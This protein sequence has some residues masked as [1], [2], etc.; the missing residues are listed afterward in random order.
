MKLSH[1]F[2][3]P[4]NRN[5]LPNFLAAHLL[6]VL[7]T[8]GFFVVA[9]T[10]GRDPETGAQEKR[11]QHHLNSLK[12]AN[13]NILAEGFMGSMT[14]GVDAIPAHLCYAQAEKASGEARVFL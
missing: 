1:L 11:L 2:A 14:F 12:D 3:R 7:A 8:S 13:G 9:Q 5:V 4:V 10:Q 6:W